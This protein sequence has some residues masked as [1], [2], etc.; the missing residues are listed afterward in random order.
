MRT[1]YPAPAFDPPVMNASALPE[2]ERS[3]V[4]ALLLAIGH[5]PDARATARD[6]LAV[7]AAQCGLDGAALW[8]RDPLAPADGPA[9]LVLLAVGVRPEVRLAEEAGLVLGPRKG[10]RVDTHMTTSDPSIYAVGDAVEVN[11]FFTGAPGLVP[12]RMRSTT[13]PVW[14]PRS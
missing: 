4:H 14:R 5:N 10:I 2:A 9:D 8:W 7:L 3:L 6:F 1:E 11:D 12:L 13:L